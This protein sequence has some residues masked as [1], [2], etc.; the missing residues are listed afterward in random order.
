MLAL[1]DAA[2]STHKRFLFHV[3]N[4]L[5]AL[6][7]SAE[8]YS[9]FVEQHLDE[10]RQRIE[11]LDAFVRHRIRLY[12]QAQNHVQRQTTNKTVGHQ[13]DSQIFCSLDDLA[14]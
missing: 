4:H 12:R 13:Q 11:Q 7:H 2:V 14:L 8:Q 1:N 10:R 5:L 6:Q 9:A 3:N